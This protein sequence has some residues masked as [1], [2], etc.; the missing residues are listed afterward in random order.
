VK[1]T[2]VDRK[3]KVPVLAEDPIDASISLDEPLDL[4]LRCLDENTIARLSFTVDDATVVELSDSSPLDGGAGGVYLYHA[5]PGT[6][7]VFGDF[8]MIPLVAD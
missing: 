1:I 3:R 7:G 2:R 4:V 6:V 5:E 8:E